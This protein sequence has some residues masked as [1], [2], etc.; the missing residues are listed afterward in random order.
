MRK[1]LIFFLGGLAS[2]FLFVVFSYLVHKNLLTGIDFDT[3]VRLQNIIPRRLDEIFS[4]F[5]S[6]G[7]F[8]PMIIVLVVVLLI[9]RKILTGFFLFSAF[10]TFH[11]FEL[12]GKY[13]VNHPP[14]PEFMLRTERIIQFDQFH[15]RTEFS[16]PSGHSGR[17][18][19][20]ASLLL[21]IIWN[22]TWSRELKIISSIL[23]VTY[24]VIMLV[25]RIY[26]GEH[27]TS[28]VIGGALLAVALSCF[29][30]SIH[31]LSRKSVRIKKMHHTTE[32]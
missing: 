30:F 22:S 18:I 16:Y 2:F 31:N 9:W 1:N 5:S 19:L 32:Q 13:V 28:D 20:I 11:V 27:W 26:L 24:V 12:F 14:P 25:S 4:I 7:S 17:A 6:I 29:V 8:E 3:T 23:I 10:V 15:V 21:F